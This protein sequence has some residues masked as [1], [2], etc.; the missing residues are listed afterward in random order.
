VANRRV[1]VVDDD[2]AMRGILHESLE[3]AGY[4]VNS[5][6]KAA[7]AEQLF[8]DSRPELAVIDYLLPDGNAIQLMERLKAVDDSVPI[9]VLT[10][11][12]SIE[13]AVEAMRQ[14]AEHFLT[15]PVQRSALLMVLQRAF[16]NQRSRRVERARKTRDQRSENNPFLGANPEIARLA[17]TAEKVLQ[18]DRP[19]LI[20]GETGVGKG[21]LAHWLHRN[22]SRSDEPFVDLNCGGLTKEFLETELF[23]HERGAFTGAVTS[24][25]GLLE[26]AHN[27]SVFLDEIGDVDLQVQPKLLKVLEEKQFRRLG[28]TR[29]RRVDIR[30]LAAT[31]QDLPQLVR[32]GKFRSDL[33]FRISTVQLRIP[34]LR[35]RV[36]DIPLLAQD[37]LARF[38]SEVGREPVSISGAAMNVLKAHS[39]P[40]NIRELRN[41]LERA[42]LLS[43]RPSL[44][45]RDLHFDLVAVSHSGSDQSLTSNERQ[46]IEQVL[47]SR[48]W[49]VRKAAQTLGVSKSSLYRKIKDFEIALPGA[50]AR[51]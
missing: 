7:E 9:V 51:Q 4:V 23:G 40:G 2:P 34:P 44:E 19:I 13:L 29:D 12:G 43:Q 42:V 38:C 31:H 10:G 36:E 49:D 22:G 35:E 24:K 20:V 33:Y 1:L 28:E 5:A 41:V 26:I 3:A 46:H 27:G 48:H 47:K 6:G 16:E 18:T 14:G 37:L 21:V 32:E 17:E 39:W 11:H 8:S 50:H 25:P 45:V 30:L 15:K